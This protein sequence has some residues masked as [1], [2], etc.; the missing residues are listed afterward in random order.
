[1]LQ[2]FVKCTVPRCV[3]T[4]WVYYVGLTNFKMF[5]KQNAEFLQPTNNHLGKLKYNRTQMTDII[6][7]I[8]VSP[9]CSG[10]NLPIK[11]YF[12]LKII[13]CTE[14]LKYKHKR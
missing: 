12:T 6:A 4:V 1:M 10:S 13:Y 2:C 3:V 7:G 11:T 14:L 5:C 9:T 8:S